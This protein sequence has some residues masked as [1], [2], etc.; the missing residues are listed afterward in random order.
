[1]FFFFHAF[2]FTFSK[3]P[4][5]RSPAKEKTRKNKWK[6]NEKICET[7]REHRPKKNENKTAAY[8]CIFVFF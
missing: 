4:V 5:I 3:V 2:F 6:K 1:L 8:K 7:K